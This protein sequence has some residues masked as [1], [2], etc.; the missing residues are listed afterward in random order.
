M[1]IID[2]LAK[3][4]VRSATNEVASEVE[5]IKKVVVDK[6]PSIVTIGVL[7]FSVFAFC[8]TSKCQPTDKV[9][10]QN[11]YFGNTINIGK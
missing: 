6:I 2:N 3:K 4:F 10:I 11:L 1:K 5:E 7:L 9:V 8:S